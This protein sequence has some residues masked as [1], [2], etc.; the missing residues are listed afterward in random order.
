MREKHKWNWLSGAKRSPTARDGP[1]SCTITRRFLH[2]FCSSEV[3]QKSS[4]TSPQQYGTIAFSTRRMNPESISGITLI[5]LAPIRVLLAPFRVAEESS[6]AL[7][8]AESPFSIFISAYFLSMT[9]KHLDTALLASF[10]SNISFCYCLFSTLQLSSSCSRRSCSIFMLSSA[11]RRAQ[12]FAIPAKNASI[13]AWIQR[14]KTPVAKPL[15]DSKLGH[16]LVTPSSSNR[17][18]QALRPRALR[19]HHNLQKPHSRPLDNLRH[20]IIVAACW[21]VLLVQRWSPVCEAHAPQNWKRISFIV[22]DGGNLIISVCET[23]KSWWDLINNLPS[24]IPCNINTLINAHTLN[25]QLHF[26][27]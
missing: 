22:Q 18:T 17:E 16:D 26:L 23:Q 4:E 20:V 9:T 25:Y 2:L 7:D 12:S 8:F 6:S 15:P 13:L 5:K 19:R 3:K 1:K 14:A 24:K 21:R 10:F 11:A 27:L